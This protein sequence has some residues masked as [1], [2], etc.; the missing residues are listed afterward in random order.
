[1][2]GRDQKR[3]ETFNFNIM[4]DSQT[5]KAEAREG[6]G[7]QISSKS[8]KNRMNRVFINVKGKLIPPL[9]FFPF[10]LRPLY[11][12]NPNKWSSLCTQPVSHDLVSSTTQVLN[13]AHPNANSEGY[14]PQRR[15]L[16]LFF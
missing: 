11:I 6:K 12:Q 9:S 10:R 1:M 4:L 7:L 5:Y 14:V 2:K 15:V 16:R 13:V 8:S 3:Y